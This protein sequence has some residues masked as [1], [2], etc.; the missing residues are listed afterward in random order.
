M[1][2]NRIDFLNGLKNTSNN[3]QKTEE[4]QLTH[5]KNNNINYD[6]Y[7]NICMGRFLEQNCSVEILE[8]ILLELI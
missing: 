5:T 6:N 8:K 3:S 1:K 7:N 4:I 2:K